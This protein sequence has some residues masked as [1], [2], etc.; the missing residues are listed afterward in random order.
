[1]HQKLARLSCLSDNNIK[2][3]VTLLC[4]GESGYSTLFSTL[5]MSYFNTFFLL[6]QLFFY[7]FLVSFDNSCHNI[8]NYRVYSVFFDALKEF[9]F[10]EVHNLW[11]QNE[12][13]SQGR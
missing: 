1:M 6:R 5:H 2:P 4:Y 3:I 11:K 13:I 7:F 8:R 10:E 12:V 9:L